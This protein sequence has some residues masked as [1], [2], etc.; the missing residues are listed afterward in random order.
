VTAG[1][2]QIDVSRQ[3]SPT[4]AGLQLNVPVELGG[5]RGA[6]VAVARSGVD[7]ARADH[8]DAARSLR[9][10]AVNAY[11]DA[12]H[13]RLVV[14][15]K[16]TEHESLERLVA[17]NER[18]LAAG[19]VPVVAV[20]QSRVEARQF[21]A[22]VLSATGDQKAADV[23]LLQLL[24]PSAVG[25]GEALDVA[26]DLRVTASAVVASRALAEL[27]NRADVRAA[28][29]RVDQAERQVKLEE[30]NRVVDVT[31]GVGWSHSF[32]ATGSPA[33]D[34]IGLTLSVPIPISHVYRGPLEAARAA[35]RQAEQQLASVRARAQGELRQAFAHFDAAASRVRLYESGTLAD[36]D[37]VL[38]KTLYNYQRGG[39]TLTDYIV[40]Q[41]TAADVHLA[42]F[43]ALADRAHALA[44]VEQASGLSDLVAF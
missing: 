1:A 21:E 39:A 5:K 29:A 22:D 8:Q 16:R 25:L 40:A 23:A 26:G 9:A 10:T 18:R 28:R 34:T 27:E 42:Y 19:D 44:A 37:Q 15:L 43:D 12:L 7:A 20:L 2:T 41:R 38:D 33:S 32:A 30:A 6:R 11:V 4:I 36:A 31:A 13:A 3:G 35:K 14:E 24:G 17:I